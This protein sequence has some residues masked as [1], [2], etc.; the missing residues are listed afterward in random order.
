M[1]YDDISDFHE[2][3]TKVGVGLWVDREFRGQWGL[4][5][6]TGREVLPPKYEDI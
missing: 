6:G 2:G 5:D 1:P 3:L 4:V